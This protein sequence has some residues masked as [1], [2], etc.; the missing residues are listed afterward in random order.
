MKQ[1]KMMKKYNENIAAEVRRTMQLLDEVKPLEVHHLFRVRLMRR[2]ED[3]LERRVKGRGN[4]R[5]EYK[6][7]FLVMLLVVNLASALLLVKPDKD[8]AMVEAGQLAESQSDDYSS[9]EFAYYDRTT[10]YER[11]TP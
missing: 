3:E 8:Q 5:S 4:T 7:A 6:L 1:E 11:T 9:Q 2:I 10:S